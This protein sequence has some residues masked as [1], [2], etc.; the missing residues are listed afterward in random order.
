[1]GREKGSSPLFATPGNFNTGKIAFPIGDPQHDII[2][3][4]SP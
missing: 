4:S 2:F 3:L 1:M